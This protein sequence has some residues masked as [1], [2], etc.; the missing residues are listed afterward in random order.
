MKSTRLPEKVLLPIAD[1]PLVYYAWKQAVEAGIGKV[2]VAVDDQRVFDAVKEFGGN[3][4]MTDNL[5]LSG[6]DRVAAA[7]RDHNIDSERIICLQADEPRILPEH[8]KAVARLMNG[9]VATLAS[10]I[11]KVEEYLSPDIV[12]VVLDKND[13]AIYFSRAPI[14]YCRDGMQGFDWKGK[15]L[16]HIGIYAFW[17]SSL[18]KA[19]QMTCVIEHIEKLEQLRWLVH[20]FKIQVGIVDHCPRGID[21]QAD[22]E[23]FKKEVEST[24]MESANGPN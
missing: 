24:I 21:T 1:K 17:R 12:K 16:K 5:L 15:F 4:L 9:D 20:G 18:L 19:C 13:K 2:F 7:A 8:I 23:E 22:Y 6:T 10:Q 3:P 14:P 11:H